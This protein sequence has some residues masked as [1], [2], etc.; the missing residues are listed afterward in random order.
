MREDTDKDN[1]TSDFVVVELLLILPLITLVAIGGGLSVVHEVSEWM[2]D[3]K[4]SELS[5]FNIAFFLSTL[6]G[7]LC[8]LCAVLLQ[9]SYFQLD[10]RFLGFITFGLFIGCVVVVWILYG[11]ISIIWDSNRSVLDIN[12]IVL[13]LISAPILVAIRHMR[14]ILLGLL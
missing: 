6:T 14:R 3:A 2:I 13:F 12:W 8:L 11:L 5:F 1:K 4:F 9:R 10:K 7:I